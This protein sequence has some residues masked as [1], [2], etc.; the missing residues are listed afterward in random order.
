MSRR[1]A[2]L[3]GLAVATG[4]VWAIFGA[5][6]VLWGQPSSG[7]S[8]PVQQPSPT[9]LEEP[10]PTVRPTASPSQSR[11][12]AWLRCTASVFVALA[13]AG[14]GAERFALLGAAGDSYAACDEPVER[15]AESSGDARGLL[16]ACGAPASPLLVQAHRH[17]SNAVDHWAAASIH[18]ATFCFT[19][20]SSELAEVKNSMSAAV[21]AEQEMTR[22][23]EEYRR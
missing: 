1:T 11:D 20:A 10:T 12:E 9:T 15:M 18:A 19:G 13:D 7:G 14:K 3:L 23:I 16:N 21:R 8:P 2:L 6:W 5:F 4:L 17:L 22:L